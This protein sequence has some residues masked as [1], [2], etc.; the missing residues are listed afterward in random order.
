MLISFTFL[1]LLASIGLGL[2]AATKV[3]N[4]GDYVSAGRSL[5]IWVVTA[6]VFA[7]WFGA[8]TVL[9][10]PAEFL[11]GDL[12]SLIADPFGAALCLILFG[13]F[14]ARKLYRM[15]LL[16]LGDFYRVRFDR[17]TELVASI[18]IAISYLGWVSAQIM[19]LGIVFNVLSDGYISQF[20]GILLGTSV[21]LIYTLFGGMW[22]VAV[23]TFVQMIVI[24][25]GLLF[26][27]WYLSG[28]TGGV[29]PVIEHA[30]QAEKFNFL[31]DL[32]AIAMLAFMSALLTMGLGSLAQQDVFQRANTSKNEN[33]AVWATVGGGVLY[34]LFAAVPIFLGYSAY[35]INPDLVNHYMQ[36]DSQQVLPQLVKQHLPLFAQVIFYGALLSVI[37]STASAT[38]LAPS[39][40]ISE[41][42]LKGFVT[43]LSDRYLLMM[44]RGVVVAFALLV[45]IYTLW[46]LEQETSIHKMVENAY[47]ITLV[48]AFVPLVAGLYWK[49]ASSAGAYLGITLGVIVWLAL[50]LLVPSLEESLPAHFIGFF[51]A[52]IGMIFGSLR[53]PNKTQFE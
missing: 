34:L 13:L 45:A 5:P 1:Y 7:T 24:V 14:L 26:I 22:S 48:V 33:V 43:G 25:L 11:E 8:E 20:H 37:M 12:G 23:T 15:N 42:I 40:I 17:R 31:P 27:A 3:K 30:A 49:R 35:L 19:A 29:A 4:M 6:M 41:N 2:Y 21:V 16:T 51:A 18:A 38:M 9:G 50:E 28:M 46:S 53:W 36:L 39:V 10:I 52:I 44:T 47:K 32:N